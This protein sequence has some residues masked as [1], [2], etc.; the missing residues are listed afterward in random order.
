[1]TAFDAPVDKTDEAAAAK[2]YVDVMVMLREDTAEAH[3]SMEDTPVM[4]SLL[5][6][7]L[8]RSGYKALLEDIYSLAAPLEAA[9]AAH[10]LW[11]RA[12][13]FDFRR[14]LKSGRLL[15]DIAFL[16]GIP[17]KDL[18][19][20]P[21]TVRLPDVGSDARLLGA[22]YVIEGASLGGRVIL[23]QLTDLYGYTAEAAACFYAGYGHDTGQRWREWCAFVEDYSRDRKLDA[24]EMLSAALET[25]GC[26]GE[27][28]GHG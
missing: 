17:P 15:Q 10:P 13:N 14:R 3:Q 25:F 11:T 8:S 1:M 12:T 19:I 27:V 4:R 9:A 5:A 21:R 6:G 26:F 24:Q 18:T 7:T 2:T 20:A 28:L 22:L 23:K 16:Q